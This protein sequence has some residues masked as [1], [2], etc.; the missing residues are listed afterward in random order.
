MTRP[1]VLIAEELSPATVEVLGSEIEVRNVD[2][3]DRAALLEA[4]KD[5][6]ALLV[7]SATQVDAEVYA[8][9]R[10]LKV[11]ARAGVGLDNVDVPA[12][13]T[14]GV[15][16]INAP[17]SNITSA[18]ELAVA[19]I[20]ASL[21]NLGRAD[22]SVKAGKWQRK[23]LAG[24]ELLGKTV[25]VVG[26]GRIGQLVAERLRPFGV[27]LLAYDPYVNHARAAELGARVVEL[28]EL[29]RE[30][31]VVTVH[32]PKTP[33]TTGLIGAEQFALA[34]PSLHVVNAARGGLIDEEALFDAL[35]GDRIA[36]AALD[37]YSSEPPAASETAKRLLDLDNV[38]LTPHLGASTA[39][40]QEK[41][42]VAVAK[43]VRLALAG[44]LVPD[45][46]NVAGGA[47]DDEVRPGVA[48]A[49]RLGQLFTVVAGE[50]PELLDIEVHGEIASRDVTALKL[51]ALR[52][53][54]RSV[55]TEQVSYV[56]APV[57]AEERGITVQLVTDETSERFRN[58]VS[59][60][61]TLRN[62]EVVTV[63]GTLSGVDQEHK[64]IEV[65]GHALDVPLSDH[66]LII[67]YEDGPGLIGTYGMRLGEA[68][69]NIAG[70]QVSRAGSTR[71]AE[72]LVVLDLD[73]SVDREFAEELGATI[74]ARSIHAVDLVY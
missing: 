3:T 33:E 5:A 41:A 26:F 69:I 10:Q 17:T 70:M 19:L 60:R 28:D 64:L 15:M 18:A 12:A 56:N 45:A 53:V 9:A 35:S 8:A 54:F 63:S 66:L 30:S 73:E 55:V 68:G 22:A 29:M 48:L 42:G 37:V 11:V 65:L 47:I 57:L 34:K 44:E 20:L 50:S 71:G 14:A 46:V 31:D 38:T 1:V 6:D 2:G 7:R 13:T 49:D 61:G 21:R 16:V 24:V 27:N 62:G 67:R 43:S 51:S 52:G 74:D 58:V 25:G 39:E 32:M 40:A 4:V 36:G 23:Q 59:L 72:A